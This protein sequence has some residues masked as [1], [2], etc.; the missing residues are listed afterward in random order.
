MDGDGLGEGGD[1]PVGE[2]ADDAAV[3]EDEG[4]DGLGDLLDFGEGAGTDLREVS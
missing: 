4:A 3:A 2:A 1:A